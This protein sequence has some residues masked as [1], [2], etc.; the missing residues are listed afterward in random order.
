MNIDELPP[1]FLCQDP[2]FKAVFTGRS[3]ESQGALKGLLSA[4]IGRKIKSASVTINEPPASDLRQ[5]SIRYDI[6]V[7]FDDGE[8]ANVEMMFHPA[9][10]EPLHMEYFLARLHAGQGIKGNGRTYKHL[11]RAWQLSIA[12]G[13]KLFKDKEYFH[14]FFYYDPE[15]QISLGGLTSVLTLE[16]KPFHPFIMLSSKIKFVNQNFMKFAKNISFYTISE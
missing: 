6:N 8:L 10:T 5:R 14:R 16:L 3:P 11:N 2:V 1:D 12:G 15:R 13:G 7:R 4:F 9:W